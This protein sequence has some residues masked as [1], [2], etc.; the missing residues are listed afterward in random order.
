[1]LARFFRHDLTQTA[2][3][4]VWLDEERAESFNG[5]IAIERWLKSGV[6]T[7]RGFVVLWN[8]VSSKSD[9]VKREIQW[10]IE[11]SG[12]IPI[13]A[14]QCDRT[15]LPSQVRRHAHVVCVDGLWY[16]QGIAEEVFS[17]IHGLEPR[18]VWVA[19]NERR[20]HAIKPDPPESVLRYLD[21]DSSDGHAATD[22]EWRNDSGNKV[23]SFRMRN[24]QSQQAVTIYSSR[25][26]IGDNH[27]VSVAVD[28]GIRKGDRVGRIATHRA[29]R[30]AWSYSNYWY[31]WMRIDAPELTAESVVRSYIDAS[32][33]ND[34]ARSP[35][36][37]ESSERSANNITADSPQ[38]EH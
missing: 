15:P 1:M 25:V 26:P 7:A 21:F 11:R 36:K 22:V 23:L 4:D 12:E 31:V 18:S 5:N 20:G 19:E 2:K 14:I 10:A 32:K 29:S 38:I 35:S 28:A 3:V 27:C 16:A 13:I 37:T 33:V 6:D 30:F 34:A 24:R 9:W 8:H 17:T